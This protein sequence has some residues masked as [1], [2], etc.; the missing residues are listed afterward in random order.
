[1]HRKRGGDSHTN[2][3]FPFLII[4]I[5]VPLYRRKFCDGHIILGLILQQNIL[6][7]LFI[8]C[9]RVLICIFWN[10]FLLQQY[11]A[12][13]E[14]SGLEKLSYLYLQHNK[15]KDIQTVQHL[16]AIRMLNVSYN[17]IRSIDLDHMSEFLGYIFVRGECLIISF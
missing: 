16:P 8:Y 10:V 12:K 5:I 4:N 15:I 17:D 14:F 6:P 11:L 1:M 9:D 2:L 3:N 13:D 7:Q